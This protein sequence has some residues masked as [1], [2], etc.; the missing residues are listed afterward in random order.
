M[1]SRTLL[2]NVLVLLFI[3][4]VLSRDVKRGL[5]GSTFVGGDVFLQGRYLEVAVNPG[6]GFGSR[7]KPSTDARFPWGGKLRNSNF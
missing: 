5:G 3:N 6:G 7:P 2:V 4:A 1:V